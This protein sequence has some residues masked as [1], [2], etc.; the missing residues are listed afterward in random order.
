MERKEGRWRRR[1]ER[2]VGK[3]WGEKIFIVNFDRR[4]QG[5]CNDRIQFVESTS[6]AKVNRESFSTWVALWLHEIETAMLRVRE[7]HWRQK[8]QQCKSHLKC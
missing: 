7:E 2:K 1:K 4:K 8:E 3:K 5:N 6:S